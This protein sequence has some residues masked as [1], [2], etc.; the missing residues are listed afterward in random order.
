VLLKNNG[1]V[2]PLARGKKIL[3]VGKSADNM[4]NQS[5]GWSLTWQGTDNKNSDYPSATP[6]WQRSRMSPARTTSPSAK[7]P[8]AWTSASSMP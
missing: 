6:S 8:P 5:G 7:T 1:G 3:V 2:L 4:A